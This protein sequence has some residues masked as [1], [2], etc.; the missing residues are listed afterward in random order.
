MTFN[1]STYTPPSGTTD[2]SL[3]N[4]DT[5]FTGTAADNSDFDSSNTGWLT[6]DVFGDGT[7]SASMAVSTVNSNGYFNVAPSFVVTDG[8][9]PGAQETSSFNVFIDY[10]A[11]YAP[12]AEMDAALAGFNNYVRR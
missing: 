6:G 3:L 7:Y 11:M 4:F 12:M 10:S 1:S 9:R 2:N 5:D 8:L